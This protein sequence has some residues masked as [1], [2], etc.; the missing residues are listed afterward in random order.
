MSICLSIEQ[1][2]WLSLSRNMPGGLDRID[3]MN[4]MIRQLSCL[5]PNASS[6]QRLDH[7]IVTSTESETIQ[8]RYSVLRTSVQFP[9]LN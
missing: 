2:D 5:F 6:F 8:M 3:L 4:D 9:L 1:F 7:K